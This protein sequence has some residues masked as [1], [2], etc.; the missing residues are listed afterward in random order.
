MVFMG[1]KQ[2]LEDVDPGVTITPL[3]KS[4][5]PAIYM[6]GLFAW[7]KTPQT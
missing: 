5:L 4:C 7:S 2:M 6:E 1:N 3:R